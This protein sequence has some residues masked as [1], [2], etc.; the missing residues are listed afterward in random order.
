MAAL[1]DTGFLYATL[2]Q[3]ER[4]HS[5]VVEAA[6][7]V[8]EPVLLPTPVTTEVA[9]LLLRDLGAS[10]V[11]DFADSL[12]TT[13]IMLLEPEAADYR[14]GAEVIR[15][16]HDVPIDFVDALVVAIAERLNVSLILTL[17]QRHFR[18]FRPRHC[19]AFEILP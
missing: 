4:Q 5:A 13:S 18:L 10:A 8:T 9:Y 3:R 12:A 14:R 1:L 11:A 15:Q 19:D 7:R 16:Y 2:N 6:R 17:D